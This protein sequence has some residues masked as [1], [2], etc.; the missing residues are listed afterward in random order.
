MH[1]IE[2]QDM[3]QDENETQTNPDGFFADTKTAV[4]LNLSLFNSLGCLLCESGSES[5]TPGWKRAL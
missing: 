3:M 2:N 4:L 5:T 1:D